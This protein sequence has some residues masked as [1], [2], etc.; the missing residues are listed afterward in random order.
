MLKLSNLDA[1]IDDVQVGKIFSYSSRI[2]Q[3]MALM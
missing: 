2:N 3:L 1:G